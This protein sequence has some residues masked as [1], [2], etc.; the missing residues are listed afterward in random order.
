MS[1]NKNNIVFRFIHNPFKVGEYDKKSGEWANNFEFLDVETQKVALY[2][3][4]EDGNEWVYCHL[5]SDCHYMAYVRKETFLSFDISAI[6]EA[7]ENNWYLQ[8]ELVNKMNSLDDEEANEYWTERW[9][10]EAM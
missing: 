3:R 5:I 2:G 7:V 1:I 6:S 8:N 4:F 9:E 10:E